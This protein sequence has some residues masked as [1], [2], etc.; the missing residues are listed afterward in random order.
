MKTGRAARRR[1]RD[2]R[3]LLVG[4]CAV[5]GI[6][7]MSTGVLWLTTPAARLRDGVGGPFTLVADD[8]KSVT[9]RSFPGK[10][11]AIYFGYTA[12]RDVCPAT[13]TN[14]AAALARLGA[15]GERVQPLFITV[16]PLRDTPAVLRRFVAN[17]PPNLRG[18]TGSA[19]ALG[20]VNREYHVVSVT[21]REDAAGAGYA[22]D[23][24]SVIYLLAPDGGFV[25]PIP[26]DASEMVMAS[27]ISRY[28]GA[29]S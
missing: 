28:V 13:M 27:A 1:E 6:L 17:F 22:V 7:L 12:C 19:E 5:V 4:A 24:S 8:G 10:Y 29:P 23:H 2:R 3:S 18:L 20:K 21:H 15:T 14:L 25:A 26:A 16:D 11:L 9:E